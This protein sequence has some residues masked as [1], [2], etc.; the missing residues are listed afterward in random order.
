VKKATIIETV[1]KLLDEAYVTT[2]TLHFSEGRKNPPL[3]RVWKTK[4]PRENRRVDLY[5]M[6]FDE[7]LLVVS[8][9]MLNQKD[10]IRLGFETRDAHAKNY[11]TGP[12]WKIGLDKDNLISI[13]RDVIE[14]LTPEHIQRVINKFRIRD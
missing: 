7:N 13:V 6:L 9:D 12:N 5:A 3:R 11:S 1:R 8:G 2:N 4:E 10:A 14:I